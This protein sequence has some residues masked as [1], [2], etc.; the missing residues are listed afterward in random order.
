MSID[1]VLQKTVRDAVDAY[2][3]ALEPVAPNYLSP[4]DA[5][6]YLGLSAKLLEAW[7]HRGEGPPYTKMDRAVRYRRADL[8]EFMGARRRGQ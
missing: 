7:R 3:C 1:A 2:L 8:D 6:K 4:S 5:A